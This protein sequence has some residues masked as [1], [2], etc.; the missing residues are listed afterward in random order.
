MLLSMCVVW[1]FSVC[2]CVCVL[3]RESFGLLS[4]SLKP[5]CVCEC[6]CVCARAHACV[7]VCWGGGGRGTHTRAFWVSQLTALLTPHSPPQP[8]RLHS[9]SG[10][11]CCPTFPFAA[12]TPL[13]RSPLTLH[14][15][16]SPQ[17]FI[18]WTFLFVCVRLHTLSCLHPPLPPHPHHRCL[19]M[20]LSELSSCVGTC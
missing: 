14:P 2:V 17:L 20:S 18:W 7:C 15:L 5:V 1:C 10:F 3:E 19:S 11:L 12:H 4:G 16:P 9:S 8:P 6:A 13:T